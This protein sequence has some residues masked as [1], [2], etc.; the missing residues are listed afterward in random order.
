MVML[1][2]RLLL[3]LSAGYPLYQDEQ[4]RFV[5]NTIQPGCSNVC[6]DL[7]S[8][9]SLF[10]FWLVQLVT[11]CL[12]YLLFVIFVVHKV[13]QGLTF[14]PR[15]NTRP[16]HN[17]QQSSFRSTVEGTLSE[18]QMQRGGGR[19]PIFTGVYILQL[20]AR[21]ILEVGFGVA[22]YYLFGFYV[23]RR[24]LCQQNPC[25]TQVD[26]YV[27]RP[28]EKTVMLTFM[29]AGGA[30]SLLL[31][32]A[33]L[34]CTIKRSV[35]PK[36]KRKLLVQRT[37]EE[38]EFYLSEGG[39]HIVPDPTPQDQEAEHAGG[40][41][42]RGASK[43]SVVGALGRLPLHRSLA[44]L[45]APGPLGTSSPVEG[46]HGGSPAQDEGP[47]EGRGSKLALCPLEPPGTPKSIRVSKRGRLKPP[48]P[49][50][51]R[52]LTQTGAGA[53]ATPRG[54]VGDVSAATA[55]CARRVGQYT[56]MK[57]TNEGAEL[58]VIDSHQG[59]EKRSEWV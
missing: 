48:P 30:L 37:Y 6:Y 1:L 16:L 28:T 35:R 27:S 44:S 29:L 9:L 55:V 34:L 47:E 12:P 19:T 51:R 38:E 49:P 5:C 24:F 33:D 43:G 2:L 42:K 39:G 40:F 36:M 21:T 11:L 56:L 41:R 20:L 18:V 26:C 46:D 7:F 58:Q 10:R 54:S 59:Q 50:P 22:Q 23:P 31:N 13:S 32:M 17:R 4:D 25:T 57:V 45:S 15:G 8:P 52:D 14:E 53:V 3:L